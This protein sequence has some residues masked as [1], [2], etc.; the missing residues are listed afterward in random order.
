MTEMDLF[1]A[2]GNIDESMIAKS[3]S[4]VKS[5][6][7]IIKF[8]IGAAACLCACLV[9]A[10]IIGQNRVSMD[11]SASNNETA[12]ENYSDE[13]YCIGDNTEE[14]AA[15]SNESYKDI[16]LTDEGIDKVIAFI[17][18]DDRELINKENSF[19]YDC[20]TDETGNEFYVVHLMSDDFYYEVTVMADL[21][22]AISVNKIEY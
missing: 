18:K 15:Q 19:V 22:E 9:T 20:Y 2:I 16:A 13:S 10:V 17:P 12:V 14:K 4:R 7:K 3:E 8:I 21:T 6:G 1:K 5:K 11:S